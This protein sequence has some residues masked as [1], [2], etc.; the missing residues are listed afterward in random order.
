MHIDLESSNITKYFGQNSKKR[1]LSDNSNE[2]EGAKKLIEGTLN[3]ST[4]S[5]ILDEVFTE[6]LKST[7]CDN[8]LFHCIENVEKQ[9]TQFFENTKE[10]KEG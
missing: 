9:I 2:E 8:I 7:D 1:D 3:T 10:M 6:N 5:D 4:D